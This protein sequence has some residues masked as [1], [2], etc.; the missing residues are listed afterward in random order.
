MHAE[1]AV[2]A[3]RVAMDNCSTDQTCKKYI[4]SGKTQA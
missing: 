2:R 3:S 1:R 4:T